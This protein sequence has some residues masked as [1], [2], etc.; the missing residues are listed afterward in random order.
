[1]II[2]VLV[3]PI[4]GSL[5]DYTISR[6]GRRKPYIFVGTILDV[7]FLIGIATSNTVLAVGAFVVLLQFS[8]NFAQG[9]FQG[10][11]PDLVPPL[12]VGLASGLVGLFTVLG[13]VVGSGLASIGLANGDFTVPTIAL[14]IIELVTMLSLFFRLDEGR[15]AKDRAGRSWTAVAKEA[16]ARDVLKERSFMFL[17]ASRFFILGGGAFLIGLLVPYLERAQ[18]VTDSGDRAEPHLRDDGHRGVVHGDRDDPRREDRRSR[19]AQ[20][21][22]LRGL[23]HR[24]CGDDDV[25]LRAVDPRLHRRGH[26]HGRRARQLPVG[27]LGP[28][29]RHHPQGVCRPV[30][31]HLQR[32]HGDQ[33]R[34]RGVHR[35]HPDRYARP[36]RFSEAGPRVAFLLAPVWFAIGALLLRPVVEGRREDEDAPAVGQPELIVS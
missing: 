3:Q 34:D 13:V 23:S 6:F 5:S 30:H 1:M 17:V 8:A 4:A 16:W 33:R 24:G 19:R 2:A 14:G 7:L 32:G 28:D 25:R 36:G 35:R 29:D 18:G 20:A 9:P 21:G 15:A 11:V 27:R 10:Y 26:P 12:Q 22:D 31:G